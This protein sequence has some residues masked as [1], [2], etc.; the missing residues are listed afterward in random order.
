MANSHDGCGAV[1]T[2]DG[3]KVLAN[4]DNPEAGYARLTQRFPL[5]HLLTGASGTSSPHVNRASHAQNWADNRRGRRDGSRLQAQSV[6]Y[7]NRSPRG[8][9]APRNGSA[10]SYA[11]SQRTRQG[12]PILDAPDTWRLLDEGSQR[13]V[14]VG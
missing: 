14:L 13:A 7:S 5:L 3:A 2:V 9:S 6:I 4:A 12:E 11:S 1:G 10:P 8:G